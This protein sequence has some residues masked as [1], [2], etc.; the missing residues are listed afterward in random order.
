MPAATSVF[1]HENDILWIIGL[2]LAIHGG[3]PAP[4][5]QVI[6]DLQTVLVAGA[7]ANQLAASHKLAAGP[8]LTFNRLQ[9]QLKPMGVEL[10]E[11]QAK[12]Q[13]GDDAVRPRV[14]CFRFKGSTYCYTVPLPYA[15]P[16]A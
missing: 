13:A 6:V 8:V 9:A 5:E 2:W 10:T 7:L 3:D 11:K 16:F 12:V 4:P 1:T 14:Y 15:Y